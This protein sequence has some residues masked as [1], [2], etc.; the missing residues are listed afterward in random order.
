MRATR[1]VA[2]QFNSSNQDDEI[3]RQLQEENARLRDELKS[4]QD[5]SNKEQK[6]ASLNAEI[7]LLSEEK[8]WLERQCKSKTF[9]YHKILKDTAYQV[10]LAESKLRALYSASANRVWS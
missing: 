10:S 1:A 5:V 2:H 6:I 3:I 8:L 4:H 9:E 7:E